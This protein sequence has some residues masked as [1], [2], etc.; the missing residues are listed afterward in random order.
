LARRGIPLDLHMQPRHFPL[1]ERIA[2]Q[3]PRLVIDHLARPRFA[4]GLTAEWADGMEAAARCGNV[5]CKVSGLLSDPADTP[6]TARS[7]RPF[8]QHVLS[9]FGT[10]RVMFGSEWPA[11][12]PAATWKETLA[13]FT[14]SIGAHTMETRERLLGAN[15]QR[16]YGIQPKA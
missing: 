5:Y 1:V 2:E 16:F 14:Q 8:V 15:A 6:W 7:I 3:V 13:A 10:D 12:L 11:C 4:L 9:V